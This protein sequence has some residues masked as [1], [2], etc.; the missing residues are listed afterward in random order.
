MG[1]SNFEVNESLKDFLWGK[2]GAGIFQSLINFKITDPHFGADFGIGM[3]GM[4][5]RV[6]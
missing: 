6:L 1:V 3:K 4:G 5:K 2:G